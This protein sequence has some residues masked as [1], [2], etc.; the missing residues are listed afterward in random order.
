M[1]RGGGKGLEACGGRE[2]R[3]GADGERASHT[4]PVHTR[5]GRT[6]ADGEC[7]ARVW[8]TGVVCGTPVVFSRRLLPAHWKLSGSTVAAHRVIRLPGAAPS[9]RVAHSLDA[10][11]MPRM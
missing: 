1:G 10:A 11:Y 8:D 6:R 4:H 2:A 9:S 7:C 5:H 3:R